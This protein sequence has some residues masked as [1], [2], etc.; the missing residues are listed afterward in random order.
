MLVTIVSDASFCVDTG[1]AGYGIWIACDRG[2]L[3]LGGRFKKQ[4]EEFKRSRGLCHC[5]RH[6]S[7][8]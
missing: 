4:D 6:S 8:Y 2:K 3:K 1:A 7:C 5:K